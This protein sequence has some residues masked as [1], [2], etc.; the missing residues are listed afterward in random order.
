MIYGAPLVVLG[1]GRICKE[2]ICPDFK[3]GIFWQ[4]AGGHVCRGLGCPSR[5]TSCDKGLIRQL[6]MAHEVHQLQC[7]EVKCLPH[8]CQSHMKASLLLARPCCIES[9]LN[10]GKTLLSGSCKETGQ[11]GLEV[12]QDLLFAS[13]A[14]DVLPSWQRCGPG[15][16]SC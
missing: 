6:E 4:I 10:I 14:R 16:T 9:G 2:E 1:M 8:C 15:C 5:V 3:V 12:S 11:P 13:L 7:A